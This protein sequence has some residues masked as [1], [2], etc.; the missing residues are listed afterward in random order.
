MHKEVAKIN[1]GNINSSNKTNNKKIISS[2]SLPEES[3]TPKINGEE[4][5]HVEDLERT[6]QSLAM[7]NGRMMILGHGQSI[8]EYPSRLIDQ[9]ECSSSST[10]TSSSSNSS[11]DGLNGIGY[12]DVEQK[13]S[14]KRSK[15]KKCLH[16]NLMSISNVNNAN[17]NVPSSFPSS[18]SSERLNGGI[19]SPWNQPQFQPRRVNRPSKIFPVHILPNLYL[20]N[21]ETAKNRE[22]LEKC[23]IRYIVNVTSDLP[24]YFEKSEQEEMED[25]RQQIVYMRIPVDDNCSHNLA[26]FFPQAISF[27]EKARNERAAVLVHC[28]AGI[29][30]SVTVC[31]AYLMYSL[32]CPLDEAFDRLLKQNGTIAPNFHFMEALTHWEQELFAASFSSSAM[33]IHLSPSPQKL[34]HLAANAKSSPNAIPLSPRSPSAF[35]Q[36]GLEAQ[37]AAVP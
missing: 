2:K 30:R 5:Q 26:Q 17:G 18:A 34:H 20:G 12:G 11:I 33:G 9:Q 21:D 36:I 22:T 15:A 29:S 14:P 25:G 19:L 6:M 8:D 37:V 32:R 1:N 23:G 3:S 31:L 16:L 35:N 24:N 10:S 13:I 27:I 4:G 7:T 28:W